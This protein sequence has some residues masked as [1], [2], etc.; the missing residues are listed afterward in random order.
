MEDPHPTG[1]YLD[2]KKLAFLLSSVL[3]FDAQLR[4]DAHM[5]FLKSDCKEC[6]LEHAGEPCLSGPMFL[7]RLLHFGGK[8]MMLDLEDKLAATVSQP[9]EMC[10]TVP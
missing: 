6:P 3:T 9:C 8:R 7:Y 1:R 4:R 2:P 10:G 5:L